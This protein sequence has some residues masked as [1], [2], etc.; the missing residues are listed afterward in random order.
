MGWSIGFDNNWNRDI[1]YGVPAVCDHPD[2]DKKIDR[3]LGYVCANQEPRGGD[4]C[5]LYFCEK[6][7][8]CY[9]GDIDDEDAGDVAEALSDC[10]ERCRDGKEPFP[11]KPDDPMWTKFKLTDKSWKA[12]RKKNGHPEPTAAMR[13][14]IRDYE[15]SL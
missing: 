15:R 14:E 2:C 3:G 1:G 11:A 8:N 13:K 5:G 4:G 7:H 9:R 12:W 10:C 6:H